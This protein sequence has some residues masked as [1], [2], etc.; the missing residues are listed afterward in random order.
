MSQNRHQ[1]RKLPF[2]EGTWFAVPLRPTGYAIGRVARHTPKGEIIVAYIF[3]PRRQHVPSLDEISDL[4]P[5]DAARVMQVG[6]VGLLDGGWAVIGN[7]SHWVRERWP[8]PHFIRRELLREVA[9]RVIY[10][11]DNPN[12]VVAEERIPYDTVGLEPDSLSG[13]IAAETELS[14]I[15]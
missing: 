1:K 12:K 8:I 15:L 2:Q 11:D 5:S 9:W 3:G 4:S 6:G 10:A 14:D 7:S 13:H